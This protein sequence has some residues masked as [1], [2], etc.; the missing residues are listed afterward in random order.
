MKFIAYFR[1]ED[2]KPCSEVI[3]RITWHGALNDALHLGRR[4]TW[5]LVTL[6][7]TEINKPFN[8]SKGIKEMLE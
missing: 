1:N 2:D 6:S 3:D 5:T 4:R 7:A 8:E